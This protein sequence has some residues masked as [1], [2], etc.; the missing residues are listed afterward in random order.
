MPL[1]DAWASLLD[2]SQS[3]FENA[4]K[5]SHVTQPERPPSRAHPVRILRA[6]HSRKRVH[7]PS[8]EHAV[9]FGSRCVFRNHD[10]ND[11]ALRSDRVVRDRVFARR[12]CTNIERHCHVR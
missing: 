6:R 5:V 3:I 1:L 7:A 9:S 11:A 8:H 10:E 4:S 12:R 2:E